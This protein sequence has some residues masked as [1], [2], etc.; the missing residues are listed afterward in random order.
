MVSNTVS[1]NILDIESYVFRFT[2]DDPRWSS[3]LLSLVV[4][5][6]VQMLK[7]QRKA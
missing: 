3:R 6:R 4:K 2:S 1:I 5:I 7:P